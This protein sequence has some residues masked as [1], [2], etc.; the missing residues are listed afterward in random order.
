MPDLQTVI[1]PHEARVNIT[2]GGNNGD[3]PDPV[4][5]DASD[6]EIR[7]WVSEAL[8]S[9]TVPGLPA[10]DDPDLDGFV[11]ERNAPTDVRPYQLIQVRPKTAYGTAG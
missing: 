6:Q 11:V 1:Q 8:R 5:A 7:T 10:A 9:G 2:F 4:R 3:L